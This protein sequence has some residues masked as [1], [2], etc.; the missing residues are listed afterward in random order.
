MTGERQGAAR[1]EAG[2]GARLFAAKAVRSL[3]ME[4]SSVFMNARK[5]ACL[6]ILVT[7]ALAFAPLRAVFP[8]PAAPG[9]EAQG[10]HCNHLQ[11]AAAAGDMHHGA[12]H[13][14][15]PDCGQGCSGSCCD[16]ACVHC[17]HLSV[18]IPGLHPELLR[19]GT[20]V[21]SLPVPYHRPGR[22]THP[23]FRPPIVS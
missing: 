13:D 20:A 18:A 21:T 12:A 10:P 19:A 15:A 23:P 7:L 8:H 5:Q 4:L 17:V 1:C 2:S 6:V 9:P 3:E 11:D 22:T 16:G 14:T